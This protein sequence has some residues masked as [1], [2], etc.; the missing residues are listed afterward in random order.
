[1]R[2]T[3]P[4]LARAGLGPIL[5][6]LIAAGPVA[7]QTATVDQ[8]TFRISVGGR[9]VGTE[10]FTIRQSGTGGNAVLVAQGEVSIEAAGATEQLRTTLR[11]VGAQL[12]PTNYELT[13]RG[14][15]PEQISGRV[16]GNRFSAT[17]RGS[18]G[19]Q[20]SE[21]LAS[22]D[23]V[24]VEDGLTHQHFFLAQRLR[25]GA[26]RIPVII[27]RRGRQVAAT[28]ASSAADRIEIGG[29]MVDARRVTLNFAGGEERRLWFDDDGRVLQLE[30][31][32]REMVAR[33]T[34]APR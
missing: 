19:E 8:G 15:N 4:R 31:P 14:A 34:A 18:S 17:I 1:M 16:A 25:S 22:G 32:A 11:A 10:S 2:F 5:A 27:P 33:R 26:A 28:V 24:L 30:I 23:A 21:Y 3:H 6:V 7:A 13:V 20:R 12:R 29:R 9:E